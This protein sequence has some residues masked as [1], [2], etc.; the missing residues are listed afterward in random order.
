MLC[1]LSYVGIA[2]WNKF[3]GNEYRGLSSILLVLWSNLGTF[4]S[5]TS[6]VYPSLVPTVATWLII[7]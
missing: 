1:T 7:V 5:G 4:G 3:P 2:C 6:L